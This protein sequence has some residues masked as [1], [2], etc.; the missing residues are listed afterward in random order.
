MRRSSV[1]RWL[2]VCLVGVAA[3]GDV[4]RAADDPIE[5]IWNDL[6][7]NAT[8]IKS[9]A[10]HMH[11]IAGL[12]IRILAD[13]LDVNAW[14]CP[15]G[16][17]P[18]VCPG[19][20][21]RF[22]VDGQLVGSVPPSEDDFNLWE[23]RLPA[24][25]A[26][27]DHVLTVKFVPYNQSTGGG[28][29]PINGFVP[30]TIHV[31]P[32][33]VHGGT[34]TLTQNLVLSG[35]TDLNWTDKTFIGNGFKVTSA[36]NYTGHVTIQDSFVSG[37]GSFN[38]AGMDVTTTSA[39]TIQN[40]TFEA[41][42]AMRFA[43]QGSA[44]L[45]VRNNELRANNM[46]TF[47]ANDPSVP[48]MLEL[49]GSTTGAKVVQGNRLGAGMLN[50]NGGSGWQIG[51]LNAGDGNVVI[52]ARAVL[53]IINSSND[54][55]QGNYLHHDY[56]GGF[57]QGFNL[58]L[59]G[60]SD[61]ELIEHN[62]IR[63][64]S[65]P[66]QSVGG[67]FR[68]NLLID[69][70]HNFWR[71][72]SDNTQIHHN[73]FANASGPNTG[74]DGAIEVYSGESGL[75]IYN[76]TFDVGGSVGQF[77]APAIKIGS[78]S[79]FGSI[80]NNLFTAFVDASGGAFISTF[81]G[82]AS[83]PRV[84]TADYNAWFNRLASSTARYLSGIVGSSPGAHD[85]QAN[86]KLAGQ[87]EI[88]YRIAEGCIWTGVCTT[89][90]VLA[91]YRDIYRPAS[92]SPLINAG[93]PA[94]G[95][96]TAI[97]AVGPDDNNPVDLFGRFLPLTGP[98]PDVTPPT[99]TITINGGAAVTS[100][101]V[102]TLTLAA[103]D[104][105]GV[106]SMQFSNDGSN[107]SALEPYATTKTW[108][109][110]AGDGAKTV[111][112]RYQDG[113]SNV[114]GSFTDTITLD[115]TVGTPDTT[116]PTVAITS[117]SNGSSVSG[118]MTITATAT[119]NVGVAGVRF[120][121]DGTQLGTEQTTAPYAMVWN[122]TTASNGAHVISA[123]ARDAANNASAPAAVNVTVSNVV[124]PPPPGG[125]VA[126]YGFEE[127][128]GGTT[129]DASGN[130]LTGTIPNPGWTTAGKFGKALIF[131]SSDLT[132]VTVA[133]APALQLTSGMTLEAWVKPTQAVPQW[134]TVIMKE[135][136]GE[137]TYAL[138]ANSDDDNPNADYTSGGQEV[139][140]NGG[141]HLP[142]NVWTHLAATFDGATL[143]LYV[144]GVL[145]SSTPTTKLIDVTDG[146]LRIGGDK[147]WFGEF[148]PGVIDEVRI[149]SRPLS[150]QEI[151]TDM[152]TPVVST[153]H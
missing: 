32:A 91:H 41:T 43:A 136:P 38:V 67:E 77:N 131:S 94:D 90:Q 29:T 80:R 87:A 138:Y 74:Y 152:A 3:S 126:A 18:Y 120:L 27:G 7:G 48:V 36:A 16:H 61:H 142:L 93:D 82:T 97:G 25:L 143:S 64:G 112:V 81:E 121:I 133:D 83:T 125:L 52:G 130:G 85:V 58:W 17:P 6:G 108:T 46:V 57:S 145:V 20:E 33:P 151:Q 44:P 92:D 19:S 24:G 14:V 150:P 99:G 71:S 55:I 76:N 60:S 1:W 100:S 111:S 106:S 50:I 78:G 79:V 47:V 104:A 53:H 107:F 34:I 59:E 115:T 40:S 109:L 37:L 26:A 102:V 62:V 49:V 84:S 123:I 35:T 54:N 127:G 65:W 66:I 140:L 73:V 28:G 5:P 23:L 89:A 101:P 114:S 119:D 105:S 122:T 56:R 2:A 22:Y 12:P 103:F 117:P 8:R 116:P 132:W 86:P 149:Y 113:A 110:T 146:D 148:F 10:Q 68:Y 96:G 88:P 21:E 153:G 45:T 75:N 118:T 134:P 4:G 70:G 13:A 129:A 42:G 128:S 141:S 72:A 11:F 95:A 144:N 63:G 137:L 51:G 124:N 39:I 147:S 98:G 30:V 139:N 9:P 15:P 69:S 31:D 135:R